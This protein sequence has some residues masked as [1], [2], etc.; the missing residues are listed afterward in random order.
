M[1]QGLVVDCNSNQLNVYDC[2]VCGRDDRF[3]LFYG[4]WIGFNCLSPVQVAIWDDGTTL[5]SV[6][7]KLIIIKFVCYYM[8]GYQYR[9]NSDFQAFVV[10]G[11]IIFINQH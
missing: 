1:V 2:V 11:P 10:S 3:R 7:H 9:L 8:D 4:T 6:M 5:F